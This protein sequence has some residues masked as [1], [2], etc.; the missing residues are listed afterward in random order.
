[1]FVETS[2]DFIMN[3]LSRRLL[4]LFQF[5]PRPF[6]PVRVRLCGSVECGSAEGRRRAEIKGNQ[7]IR[8]RLPLSN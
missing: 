2:L 4:A 6:S 8:A 1:M 7:F 3:F 5:N